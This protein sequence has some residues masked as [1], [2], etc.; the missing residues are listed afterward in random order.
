M[1]LDVEGIYKHANVHIHAGKIKNQNLRVVQKDMDG[2]ALLMFRYGKK[3][4]FSLPLI[5]VAHVAQFETKD[6][7]YVGADRYINLKDKVYSLLYLEDMMKIGALKQTSEAFL[8]IPKNNPKDIALVVSE[9]LD[10]FYLNGNMEENKVNDFVV[11]GSFLYR[12]KLAMCLDVEVMKQ[13]FSES[14]ECKE[15]G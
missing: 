5:D 9:V 12:E 4:T 8:I 14:N 10:V 3:E 15:V 1:I 2:K 7:D 6:I 13:V 11:L